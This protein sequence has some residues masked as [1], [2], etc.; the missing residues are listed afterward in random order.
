[1]RGSS[2][3]AAGLDLPGGAEA[4][5]LDLADPAGFGTAL[6]GVTR[7]FL[8]AEPTGIEAFV[9]TAIDAGVEQVVLLSSASVLA[10]GAE[11][12]PLARH[13]LLVERALAGSSL[14]TTVL[15][16]DAFATNAL[17]WSRDV[18]ERHAVELPYPDAHVAPI[19]SDDIADVAALALTGTAPVGG[20]LTL[21]GPRSLTFREQL[22]TISALLGHEIAVHTITRREAAERM[23]RFMPEPMAT[24]LLDLW[25]A[26]VEPAP[27][28]PATA[29]TG[30]EAR[31]FQDWAAENLDR[32]R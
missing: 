32:F 16:P 23:G 27:V 1:M 12:D 17:A 7:A 28:E 19:H 10:P 6:A 11:R 24:S 18:R 25:A 22:G 31:T 4:V 8:Y 13:H 29:L 26:A 15:R 14:V 5:A 2:R 3:D 9:A 21:T 30:R 20:A